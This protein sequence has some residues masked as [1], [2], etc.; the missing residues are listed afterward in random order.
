MLAYRVGVR[1]VLDE[2][3]KLYMTAQDFH[4]KNDNLALF[5]INLSALGVIK[6]KVLTFYNTLFI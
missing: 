5:I 4:I 2:I 6:L 1:H 3:I